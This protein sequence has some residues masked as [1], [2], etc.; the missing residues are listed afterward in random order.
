MAGEGRPR[1]T[2]MCGRKERRGWPAFA[3]HDMEFRRVAV[4]ALAGPKCRVQARPQPR[5]KHLGLSSSNGFVAPRRAARLRSGPTFSPPEP[6]S[7]PAG[8]DSPPITADDP[9][10][11]LPKPRAAPGLSVAQPRHGE[12]RLSDACCAL[13]GTPCDAKPCS[14]PGPIQP[15]HSRRA[16]RMMPTIPT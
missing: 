10:E 1:T 2:L 14:G 15:H 12:A 7:C 3:G 9:S 16:K 11:S 8:I 5:R 13:A 4:D 6:R